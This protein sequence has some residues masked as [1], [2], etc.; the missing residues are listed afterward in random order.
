MLTA[1][2]EKLNADRW[3]KAYTLKIS[4]ILGYG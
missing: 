1:V 2:P 4:S 3:L